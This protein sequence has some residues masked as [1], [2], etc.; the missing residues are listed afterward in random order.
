MPHQS[1]GTVRTGV[2]REPITFDF[3]LYGEETFTVVPTPSFGDTF[4]LHDAPEPTNP[5]SEL[6]LVRVLTRFVRR[7]LAPEDR[8]RFDAALYRIPTDRPDIIIECA[9]WIT[10]QVSTFPTVPPTTSSGGRPRSGTHSRPKRAGATR[11]KR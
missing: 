8:A 4:D 5:A 2:E 9:A 11:S 6:E 3:G 7:L 10:P 1:F